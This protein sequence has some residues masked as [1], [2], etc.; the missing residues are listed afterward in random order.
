MTP[1]TRRPIVGVMGSGSE[2]YAELAQPLGRM[3]ARAG[4]HLLTGG[5][6][7]VMSAVSQA[8]AAAEPRAGSIIGVVPGDADGNAP[9]GYPNPFVEIV[10]RTHLPTSG[11]GGSGPD[12][13]NHINILSSHAVVALPGSAGTR[14]EIDLA[15]RYGK[16]IILMS[17]AGANGA[18]R[19][20]LTRT[21]SIEEVRAFLG[22]VLPSPS[23]D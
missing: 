17:K 18:H 1:V 10:I 9:T 11:A 2:P 7:G 4:Y 20:G 19:D 12:S 21:E 8:F 22:Q 3:L 14:S 6:R 13:R 16:P 15:L 23:L 5:G